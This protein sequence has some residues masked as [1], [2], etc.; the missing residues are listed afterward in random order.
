MS[1]GLF[2]NTDELDRTLI[3]YL[4]VQY[5]GEPGYKFDLDYYKD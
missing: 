2:W 1:E 4:F 5:E 3:L